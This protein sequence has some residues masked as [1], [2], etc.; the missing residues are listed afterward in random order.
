MYSLKIS[1]PRAPP[2][3]D[4]ILVA[5]VAL[6]ALASMITLS[7]AVGGATPPDA[8]RTTAKERPKILSYAS[9]ILSIS[10]VNLSK[11]PLMLWLARLKLNGGYKVCSVALAAVTIAW[12]LFCVFG[13]VFQCELPQPWVVETGRCTSLVSGHD[14][15]QEQPLIVAARALDR[16]RCCR[17]RTRYGSDGIVCHS[18]HQLRWTETS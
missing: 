13:V 11:M 15:Q 12:M 8:S 3:K 5:F 16:D 1:I 18:S 10:A 4:D 2:A 14:Q 9:A 7:T 6:V 17:H